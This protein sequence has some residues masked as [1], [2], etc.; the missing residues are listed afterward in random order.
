MEFVETPAE[1]FE[2]LKDFPFGPRFAE[3]DPAGLRMHY[4][5]E[6][7]SGAAPVLMLHGERPGRTST[8][9]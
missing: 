6:G 1:R 7:P 2:G 9:R 8:A 4:V 3:V 5:D